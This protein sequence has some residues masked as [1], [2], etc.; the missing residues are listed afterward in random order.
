[1][2]NDPSD[3]TPHPSHL[4]VPAAEEPPPERPYRARHDGWTAERQN[5]FIESLAKTRC[6]RDASRMAGI[7]WN[8]AYRHRKR[9]AAF[10]ERW[11]LAL[12]RSETTVGEVVWQRA[13]EGVEEDVW[14]YGKVVGKRTKY[15]NDLLRLLYQHDTNGAGRDAAGRFAPAGGGTEPDA[16]PGPEDE[17]PI[18]RPKGPITMD[19]LK[20]KFDALAARAHKYGK[21]HIN[22]KTGEGMTDEVVEAVQR[23]IARGRV[24]LPKEFQWAPDDQFDAR[25]AEFLA[26]LRG[27]P[28]TIQ[29]EG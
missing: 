29:Q 10:A 18:P 11:D 20:E 3:D 5:I 7:S 1:M 13:V 17:G 24:E 9:S 6:V 21:R 25:E 8:S 14:Y 16:L 2:E 15:A 28:I 4:P 26:G 19:N 12:R 27:E 22:I 23:Y